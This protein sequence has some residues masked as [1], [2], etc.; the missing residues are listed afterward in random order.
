PCANIGIRT[1]PASGLL[2]IDVDGPGGI[3]ALERLEKDYGPLP[4]TPTA[5]TGGGGR[6]LYFRYP[7]DREIKNQTKVRDLPIDVRAMGGYVIGPPSNHKS[8]NV[9]EWIDHTADVPLA[10]LPQWML[11]LVLAKGG[12]D[13]WFKDICNKDNLE[14]APGVPEGQ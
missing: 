3:E 4:K 5:R 14:T 10:D 8:G 1:G 11:E 9:Y 13:Q 6:H 2:V 12:K 7:A